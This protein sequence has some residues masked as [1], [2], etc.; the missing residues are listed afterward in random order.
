MFSK[1]SGKYPKEELLG[2]ITGIG[3]SVVE[4]SWMDILDRYIKKSN[5]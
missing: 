2:Y 3:G 1:F 5:S 4:F